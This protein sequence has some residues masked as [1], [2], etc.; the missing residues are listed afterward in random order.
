MSCYEYAPDVFSKLR[1]LDG[2]VDKDLKDSMDPQI[3]KNVEN[4]FKSG[5][6]MG[7]SGSFFFFSHDERFLIKTMTLDDF[8]AWM[9]MFEEYYLH[10]TQYPD[11]LIARVYGVYSIRVEGMSIVYYMMMGNTKKIDS[12]YMR[13]LYDL[14][15]SM[16]KREI[17]AK[18]K[19]GKNITITDKLG[20]VSRKRK[21][22]ENSFKNTATLK[23]L[24]LLNLTSEQ[25]VLKFV[26]EDINQIFE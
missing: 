17:F 6:G 5:E 3:D 21:N 11:S 14:K 8:Q 18:D 1:S 13:R 2:F 4:I 16:L 19:K 7:K 12:S 10:V 25:Y 9:K 24:N 23:D 26:P 22:I 20:H 15:G